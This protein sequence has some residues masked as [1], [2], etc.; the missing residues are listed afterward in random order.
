MQ[1]Y[2]P[3]LVNKIFKGQIDANKAE[4]KDILLPNANRDEFLDHS[5]KAR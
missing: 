1:R 4:W 3:D 2:Q 5:Y